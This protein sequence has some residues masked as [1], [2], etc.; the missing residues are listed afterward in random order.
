MRFVAVASAVS[1]AARPAFVVE[2]CVFFL[3]AGGTAAHDFLGAVDDGSSD[4]DAACAFD[5]FEGR[6][7]C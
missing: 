5:A 1:D 3:F 7:S 6:V 4:V 2:H